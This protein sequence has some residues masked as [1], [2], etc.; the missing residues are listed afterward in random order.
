MGTGCGRYLMGLLR[1]WASMVDEAPSLRRSQVSGICIPSTFGS[2]GA[3]LTAD[4]V[5]RSR[6][7]VPS[8]FMALRNFLARACHWHLEGDFVITLFWGVITFN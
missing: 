5:K 7:E 2:M 6:S 3:S 1:A 8:V 4:V